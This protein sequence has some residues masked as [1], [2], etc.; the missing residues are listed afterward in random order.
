M[1]LVLSIIVGLLI[2]WNDSRPNWDDTGISVFLL[3]AAAAIFA[4]LARKKPWLIAL[5]VGIWIPL[6]SFINNHGFKI[7]LVFIPAFIG[8]YIGYFA[9]KTITS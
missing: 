5:S 3:I 7:L 4:F 1:Y 8:A 6:F 9:R 2:A